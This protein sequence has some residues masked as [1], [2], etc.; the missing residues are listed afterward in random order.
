[1]ILQH[2]T[3]YL[4]QPNPQQTDINLYKSLYNMSMKTPAGKIVIN[5]VGSSGSGKSTLLRSVAP[6]LGAAQYEPSSEIR[7]YAAKHD[8]PLLRQMDYHDRM[9]EMT[10]DDPDALIRPILASPASIICVASLR[11]LW[12]VLRLKELGIGVY[13]LWLRSDDFQDY[14]RAFEDPSRIGTRQPAADTPWPHIWN[15][16]SEWYNHDPRQPSISSVISAGEPCEII[17]V[18]PYP[19][20]PSLTKEQ[21]AELGMAACRR[22]LAQAGIDSMQQR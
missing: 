13:T 15:A 14:R 17:E 4:Y 21:V 8:L 6:E 11:R 5:I 9:D 7:A 1:M 10:T 18:D 20:G 22:F 3:S 19:D 2:K 16:D 12:D